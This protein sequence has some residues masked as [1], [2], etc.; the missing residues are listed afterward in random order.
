MRLKPFNSEKELKKLN[1]KYTKK[2]LFISLVV[3]VVMLS[4]GSSYAI[5][6]IESQNHLVIKSKVG[7]FSTSDIKFRVLVDGVEKDKIPENSTDYIG[8]VSCKNG[9][10]GIYNSTENYVD[11][12]YNGKDNCSINFV[13]SKSLIDLLLTQYV[14]DATFGLV[15]DK[16]NENIYYYTG[17]SDMVKNNFLWYGGHQWRVL[18]FDTEVRTLTLIAQ[19]SLTAIYPATGTWRTENTYIN[20]FINSWLNNYFWNSLNANV[21][22]NI[23]DNTFN[24]GIDNNVSEITTIQKVGLLDTEQYLRAGVSDSYLY[25]GTSWWLG[26]SILKYSSSYYV[27]MIDGFYYNG[28]LDYAFTKNN[29][30]GVRPVIKINDINITSGDGSLTNNY[31]TETKVTNTSNIQVGEYINVPYNGSDSACGSDKQCTM[32]VVSK[33]ANSIK[34]V[35]NGLLPTKSAWA[36]DASDNITTNDTIYTNVLNPFIA[37]IDAK[38]ITEGTFGVGM[39]ASGNSYTVPAATTI[40]ASVGLPTIGEI[41]SSNDFIFKTSMGQILADEK[42]IENPSISNYWTMNRS[43]SAKINSVNSVGDVDTYDDPSSNYGVRPTFYLKSGLNF[44]G[45]DGTPQN[46]YTLD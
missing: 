13:K 34:V 4:I 21:K 39:Y 20:S 22:E 38:Y 43:S 19:Q 35:L 16:A 32:R 25:N 33:N 9:S 27:Q 5:F 14:K 36:N 3:L 40:T 31:K 12:S 23:I 8:Y 37:N 29:V 41:F 44:T 2:H 18:E 10:M 24:I 26:N 1:K 30:L 46:P 17:L 11:M 42:T 28:E 6:S 15:K 45:G 7:E